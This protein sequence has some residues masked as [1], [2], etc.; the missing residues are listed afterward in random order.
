[1]TLR[2]KLAVLGAVGVVGWF[3]WAPSAVAED[4]DLRIKN[5]VD[6]EIRFRD[7]PGLSKGRISAQ[8]D[9][10]KDL[11][12]HTDTFSSL[13]LHT[14]LR[15]S[16]DAAY[17][18]NARHFGNT[19]GGS[20]SF[21][22]NNGAVVP[23]GQGLGSANN[24]SGVPNAALPPGNNA[25]FNTAN[26]PNQGLVLVDAWAGQDKGV[27]FATPV[28]PCDVDHRGCIKGYMDYNAQELAAPEFN[29]R[30]DFLREAYVDGDIPI[31]NNT[32][33]LRVG[34]QQLVW[35]RTDLFRVLDVV[36]PVDY[37]RNNIYDDLQDI[38]IPMGML[39]ADYRMGARGPFDD[40]NVQ[41]V[42]V[43]EPWRP[44]NLGQAGSTNNPLGAAQLFR[45]LKNCWDNG[46][47]VANFANGAVATDF[48]PHQ[49]GIRQANTPNYTLSNTTFGGKVEGELKGVGFS[50]NALR[51]RSQM[52]SLRGAIPSVNTFGPLLGA[53]NV[54]YPYMIAFDI[55][56]PQ[57]TLYGGS[58]DFNIEPID[59][60]IRMETVYTQGEE[61]AD[62]AQPQLYKKS[63][64]I[65]YVIG[66]DRNTFIRFLNPN[67]A[68]LFSA[69]LFGQHINDY[70]L[71]NT[72]YGTVGMPDFQDSWIGTLLIKG[73]YVSD[74]ISPQTVFARD[75]KARANVIEP[76]VE[77]TPSSR[78]RFRLG[79]NVKF[80]DYRT[81]FDDAHS[82]NPY[83]GASNN[84]SG[85]P[86]TGTNL[87]GD[88]GFEPLGR[89]KDGVIGMAHHET[90][91]FANATFRF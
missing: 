45:G 40:L 17:D 74:T 23:F 88:W 28:R 85:F 1:M 70:E 58:L 84:A 32:L 51:F 39:R 50:V 6:E 79:A 90:E 41:G 33:A 83:T 31:G 8:S 27:A 37:S 65:R 49:I 54:S 87:G 61:F 5:K 11:V 9:I 30:L 81:S 29:D 43:L 64:V 3:S 38:R 75:F 20:V 4:D 80:G 7:G 55:N 71:R 26:N 62:T 2:K 73:W 76:S 57:I 46:C 78:W 48:G 66:A 44:N 59:T 89:F 14:T 12:D 34:R 19:A 60:A 16:Y 42:W 21:T 10:D 53:N 77:W 72:G 47:T 52:P 24:T 63:D 86:V 69:Q 91:V 82:Q 36:N 56:F 35:G 67:R 22:N 15:A 18:L 68:F 13:R 25:G